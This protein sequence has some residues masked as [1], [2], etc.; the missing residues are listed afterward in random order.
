MK[1][2]R[3]HPLD[4]P[5]RMIERTERER[6]VEEDIY[7]Y[8]YIYIERERE[9]ERERY[10]ERE[11]KGIERMKGAQRKIL[12]KSPEPGN[13]A[14]RKVEYKNY[15][16]ITM[17]RI[18][19][20][21]LLQKIITGNYELVYQSRGIVRLIGILPYPKFEIFLLL[22]ALSFFI[23]SRNKI[24]RIKFSICLIDLDNDKYI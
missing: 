14:Q 5:K 9:R 19:E 10:R 12:V 3:K 1:Q 6:K 23:I 4:T 24:I 15:H 16:A 8:I 13:K 11:V 7:I 21:K 2:G 18:Y 17:S 20:E 22:K